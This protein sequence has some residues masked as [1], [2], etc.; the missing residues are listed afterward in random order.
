MTLSHDS[1]F[2]YYILA[3]E[4]QDTGTLYRV[5]VLGGTPRR[6]VDHVNG[7]PTLSP[8]DSRVAFIRFKFKP[9]VLGFD[10]S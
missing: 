6:I 1:S 10:Y 2:L 3:D 7:G 5:S 8:D 9:G 4:S